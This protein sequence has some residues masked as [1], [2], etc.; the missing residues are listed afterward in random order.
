MLLWDRNLRRAPDSLA[1]S[2][3]HCRQTRAA[4][5]PSIWAT[6][7]E[8]LAVEHDS[9]RT[10]DELE[11]I[12]SLMGT[13][14][15]A[16]KHCRWERGWWVCDFS[17]I[18]SDFKLLRTIQKEI[19]G[20]ADLRWLPVTRLLGHGLLTDGTGDGIKRTMVNK[21]SER[22]NTVEEVVSWKWFSGGN[23]AFHC[24]SETYSMTTAA[25]D[26]FRWLCEALLANHSALAA[27]LVAG[28]SLTAYAPTD[29]EWTLATADG[30][31]ALLVENYPR[32]PIMVGHCQTMETAE[33]L[34]AR[35]S[36]PKLK[37]IRFLAHPLLSRLEQVW[38]P[39][40]R[41]QL[42]R[43]TYKKTRKKAGA[44]AARLVVEQQTE[45]WRWRHGRMGAALATLSWS[46]I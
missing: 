43:K 8:I 25:A 17:T 9:T 23:I 6:G 39:E 26:Q 30:S 45:N 40:Q 2:V 1:L 7:A 24:E 27:R 29:Q 11:D 13:M 4:W 21:V 19:K 32:P 28:I 15:A 3:H 10:A 5:R 42:Q 16:R 35:H 36:R 22:G 12:S 41:R 20:K 18:N 46:K 44:A 38:A 34:A 31:P 33:W 14:K 37:R